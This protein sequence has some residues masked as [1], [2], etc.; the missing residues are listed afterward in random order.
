MTVGNDSAERS[1]GETEFK[2]VTPAEEYPKLTA[3]LG[4]RRLFL[5]REDLHPYGSHKGRSIPR[6]IDLYKSEGTRRFAISSSGNAGLAAVR[7]F[8]TL[9]E[10]DLSLTV[11]IGKNINEEKKKELAKTKDGRIEI[12]EEER[13]KQKL[14]EFTKSGEVRSLRQSTDDTA[15]IGYFELAEE[16]LEIPDVRDIFTACSSGTTAEGLAADIYRRNKLVA[17][18]ITQTSGCNAIARLLLGKKAEEVAEEK[19][20]A[21]AIVDKIGHRK[22]RVKLFVNKSGGGAWIVSN[23]EILVAQKLVKEKADLELTPNG[24]LAIA[25]LIQAVREN[26]NFDGTVVCLVG[27]K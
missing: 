23:E 21:D 14:L 6:M 19:S 11:F 20:L 7:H 3:S 10:K 4:L 1:D 12:I 27:G 15:L 2:T 25:G 22:E 17:H 8:A 24:V 16:I 13:P 9:S 26:R 5:K 18:H